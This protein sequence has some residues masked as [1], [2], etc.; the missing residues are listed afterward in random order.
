M[1]P[2][3]QK[4][5]Q[6]LFVYVLL[7]A[8]SSCSEINFYHESYTNFP[9]NRWYKTKLL[10][11]DFNIDDSSSSYNLSLDVGYVFGTQFNE[12]P[13]TFCITKPN[14]KEQFIEYI[15]ELHNGD[16]YCGDCLGDYCDL[17]V[18]ISLN[19]KFQEIGVYKV[20]IINNFNHEF[21]P[22]IRRLGLKISKNKP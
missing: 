4:L 7:I 9:N 8:L 11:F 6:I 2:N 1:F 16:K 19:Y 14:K 13:L 15:L 10:D 5:N 18:P 21:L 20:K 22:N 12:V 17:E 3:K